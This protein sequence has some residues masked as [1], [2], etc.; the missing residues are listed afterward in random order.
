MSRVRMLVVAL[1]ATLCLAAVA[2]ASHTPGGGCSD[3]A[4]HKYWPTVD[5]IF[6]K[7]ADGAQTL[8]GSSRSDELLGHHGSDTLRGGGASDILWG[9]WDAKNQPESQ[10]DVIDGGDGTDFIYGSHGRNTIRAGAGN[11][12]ISVHYGR[13]FVDCGP[14]R[15]IYHVAR[16]R[17][18]GYRFRNCEKVDYRP[19]SVRGGPMKPLS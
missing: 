17:R 4:S 16:S 2:A 12:V 11:D 9:D 10:R 19:E 3:C 1:A 14:G 13:G 15:D 6:K 7:A 5:G 18:R 8:T